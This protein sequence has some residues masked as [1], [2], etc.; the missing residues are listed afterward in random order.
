[1]EYLIVSRHTAAIDFICSADRRFADAPSLTAA[2][3]DDVR[4][5]VVAGNLPLH[6]AAL[7]AE[8]VAVEFSGNP[9]RGTEYGLPEMLAAGA[10]L[11]NYHVTVVEPPA[12][13]TEWSDQSGSRGRKAHLILRHQGRIVPFLGKNIPGVVAI[14][15][16][17]YRKNGKWSHNI[18]RLRL[19]AGVSVAFQGNSGWETGTLMESLGADSWQAVATALGVA[20]MPEF[21]GAFAEYRA[22]D[23][24][25]LNE[26]ASAIEAL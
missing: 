12:E 6:L 14:I 18:F 9:P 23:A 13:I 1:M 2:T 22:E 19:G 20:D 26:R 17:D 16:Q 25:I 4:G 24:R 11:A 10:R 5:K 7:A 3:P 8:I 21:H 15:G